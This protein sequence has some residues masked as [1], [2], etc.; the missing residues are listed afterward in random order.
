MSRPTSAAFWL[1]T[2]LRDAVGRGAGA[3]LKREAADDVAGLEHGGRNVEA[4]VDAFAIPWRRADGDDRGVGQR[5]RGVGAEEVLEVTAGELEEIRLRNRRYA[6]QLRNGGRA[7]R[8]RSVHRRNRPVQR[9]RHRRYWASGPAPART[10][11]RANAHT[12]CSRENANFEHQIAQLLINRVGNA[13]SSIARPPRS[14]S[15][16]RARDA[17]IT[18]RV[19]FRAAVRSPPASNPRNSFENTRKPAWSRPPA[20]RPP[21]GPP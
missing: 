5:A 4:V 19:T 6:R 7:R 20:R 15:A 11:D 2:T 17:T 8:C 3:D 14:L 1:W 9:R 12:K 10:P 16:R 21:T 13:G 18:F